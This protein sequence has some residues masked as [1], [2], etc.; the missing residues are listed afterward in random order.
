MET[1][2]G[3]RTA[4]PRETGR[5]TPV[6]ALYS[7]IWSKRCPSHPTL[8]KEGTG[9]GGLQRWLAPGPL[10]WTSAW[11]IIWAHYVSVRGG[12]RERHTP[13]TRFGRGK[14]EGLPWSMTPPH[15]YWGLTTGQ[16]VA[17]RKGARVSWPSGSG[18]NPMTARQREYQACG[19]VSLGEREGKNTGKG[20]IERE[21][22][23][24]NI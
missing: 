17:Q 12:Q 7:S 6:P 9:G 15:S 22:K 16:E 3:S 14:M 24:E 11:R 19:C 8:P 4:N 18:L 10:R 13:R 1:H 5:V 21:R 23:K 2:P 20:K